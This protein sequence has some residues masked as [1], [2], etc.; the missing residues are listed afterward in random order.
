[1]QSIQPQIYVT[2]ENIQQQ[3]QSIQKYSSYNFDCEQEFFK[4]QIQKIQE[5]NDLFSNIKNI[6][7][8]VENKVSKVELKNNIIDGTVEGVMIDQMNSTFLYKNYSKN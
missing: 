5:K 4:L 8:I 3:H 1:L 2:Q 6:N 7:I